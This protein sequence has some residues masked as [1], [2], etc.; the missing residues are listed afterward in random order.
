ML[1]SSR[2]ALS[3]PLA[4]L[5]LAACA[6]APPAPTPA[7]ALP[8]ASAAYIERDLRVLADDRLAGREAGSPGYDEAARYVAARFAEVGLKPG[9]ADGSYLQPVPLRG[10]TRIPEQAELKLFPAQGKARS[11]RYGRDYYVSRNPQAERTA[12]RAPLVFAG[13]GVVSPR[14]KRDDYAGLDVR[15]KIVVLLDGGSRD[16]PSEERAY[17]SSESE[18]EAARRGAVGV[19]NVPTRES[20]QVFP[21]KKVA[22]YL[23]REGMTW[24]DAQGRPHVRDADLALSAWL[25][26]DSAAALFNGAPRSYAQILDEAEKG[27]V[28]GFEL[29]GSASM[30]QGTRN[31]NLSSTN[32]VGVLPGADPL[33]KNE[34]IVLSGHL[35]HLGTRPGAKKGEDAIYNGAMD[36]AAGIATLI[37]AARLAVASG[38]PPRR[39]LVFLAVTAEEK[40]LIG[41][42]Y[43][44]RQPQLS[45]GQRIV[46]N[47]NLDMP[48][49]SF[50][51]ADVI[52]FGASHSSLGAS[53]ERAAAKIGVKLAPDPWPQEAIFVRSDHYRFVQQGVPA[54][55]LVTGTTST[56]PK[57]DG[58]KRWGEFLGQRYHQVSDDLNQTI[59]YDV[60]AKFALINYLVTRELADAPA[61]P[62][63]K[64]GDFFAEIY[65]R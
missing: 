47:I 8:Q 19:I 24:L 63:W 57:E 54:V 2:F 53:V 28:R 62:A 61:A 5:V 16:L 30:A 60:G 64:D 44:A 37:E 26:M 36:N 42:D 23:P 39:T 40:G 7:A 56:D 14:F 33:L 50:D 15:G 21:W 20:E 58:A 46:G 22:E 34:V 11:L 65:A 31:R 45:P 51:F 32:V 55:F 10:S 6:S 59:R 27:G 41:A 38:Q 3:L 43:Y 29:P 9:G 4:S 1:L 18:M 52:A 13:Y 12:L 35:D 49:L 48:L 17:F 25:N